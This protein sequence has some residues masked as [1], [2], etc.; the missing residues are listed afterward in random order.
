MRII[1]TEGESALPSQPP[2][3]SPNSGTLTRTPALRLPSDIPPSNI[4]NPGF[5]ESQEE[6][7][8]LPPLMEHRLEFA[9]QTEPAKVQRRYNEFVALEEKFANATVQEGDQIKL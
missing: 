5:S 6:E 8:E 9:K 2:A 7:L 3:H 4:P 1:K